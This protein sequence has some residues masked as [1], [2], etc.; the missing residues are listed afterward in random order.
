M[1]GYLVNTYTMHKV[2]DNIA[3][4]I[5]ATLTVVALSS[6]SFN[7]KAEAMPPVHELYNELSI[8]EKQEYNSYN[9]EER[10]N[11][12]KNVYIYQLKQALACENC[13]EID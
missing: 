6:C 4:I 1:S 8:D 5:I 12:N 13:D 7:H 2:K 9:A 11:V 10:A 3:E